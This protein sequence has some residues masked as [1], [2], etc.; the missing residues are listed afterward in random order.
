MFTPVNNKGKKMN[1]KS[2][3]R[4]NN[5]NKCANHQR[6]RNIK[7]IIKLIINTI[8]GTAKSIK[9]NISNIEPTKL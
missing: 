8:I 7:S 3:E 1:F 6:K 9:N 4:K 5:Y 2:M